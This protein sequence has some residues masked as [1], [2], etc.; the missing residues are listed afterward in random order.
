[1]EME[2]KSIMSEVITSFNKIEI[3][4]NAD[5]KYN[6]LIPVQKSLE[7]TPNIEEIIE[8]LVSNNLLYNRKRDFDKKKGDRIQIVFV[9][10]KE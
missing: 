6:L 1:M 8:L 5:G 9:D 2:I 3:N 10:D 7:S 4:E